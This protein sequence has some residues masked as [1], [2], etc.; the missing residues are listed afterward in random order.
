MESMVFLA[1][2]LV[3]Y[4]SLANNVLSIRGFEP[5]PEFT[6]VVLVNFEL[7]RHLGLLSFDGFLSS[8][9]MFLYPPFD[10]GLIPARHA[11]IPVLRITQHHGSESLV[12]IGQSQ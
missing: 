3:L 12:I 6:L 9:I 4:L 8:W 7:V 5:E 1:D 2:S 10:F 11:L